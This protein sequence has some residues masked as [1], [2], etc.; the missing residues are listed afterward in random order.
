MGSDKGK[1]QQANNLSGRAKESLRGHIGTLG[2]FLVSAVT[3]SKHTLSQVTGTV[4]Q[5][6]THN[7]LQS[8]FSDKNCVLVSSCTEKKTARRAG[9]LL[10]CSAPLQFPCIVCGLLRMGAS[11]GAM[12]PPLAVLPTVRHPQHTLLLACS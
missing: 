8:C 1:I 2:F 5:G 3:G 4:V 10:E 6:H 7:I 12:L 11:F 9:F